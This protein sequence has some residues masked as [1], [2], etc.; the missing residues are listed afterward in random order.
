MEPK[1]A[2]ALSA[3]RAVKEGQVVGL[4]TGSTVYYAIKELGRRV[5][6]ED[7]DILGVPTSLGTELLAVEE[8][9]KLTTLAE[10][11]SLDLA[12]DGAD[13]VDRRLNLIKG[14]GGAHTREK[15]VAKAAARF[16]VVVDEAKLK[17]WLSMP[18]PVEVLPFSRG[19]AEEALKGLGGRPALRMGVRKAGPVI[20]DNGN[21]ILDV[22]FGTIRNPRRL[23]EE[24]KRVTGVVESGVFAGYEPEVHVGPK[25]GGPVRILRPP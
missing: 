10:H 23:E 2:A 18:V 13:E 8:G 14:G 16:L 11:P 24:I 5:R 9:I 21:L 3:A 1:E 22:S 6:E 15:A 20:T 7:L 17:E 4:G 12:I 19:L 25:D